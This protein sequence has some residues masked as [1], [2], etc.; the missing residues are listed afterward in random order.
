VTE[1][2]LKELVDRFPTL[3]HMAEGG[4]WPSIREHGLL[5]TS[6][7]LDLLNVQGGDRAAIESARRSECAVI[8]RPPLGNVV[9]RDQKP[10][11]DAGLR[12][13]LP[14][15]TT[16]RD[17]YELLN[18]RV[19]FWLTRDRLLRLLSAGAYRAG[20]H[21]VLELETAALVRD[22]R[23]L[24]WLCPM[25]SG[26]TKPFA[27]PRGPN[28]FARI[29]D[30]PYAQWCAKRPRGEPVVELCVDHAVPDIEPYVRRVVRMQ[31]GREI[32]DVYRREPG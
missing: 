19:F 32:G 29:P 30:Y 16:P 11:T 4:S 17:W 26:C 15:G 5:S 14:P 24:I 9:I 20:E 7:L 13:A 31:A 22:V 8:K 23:P 2:E 25:N 21:D 1:D 12:R 27:H 28:T 6:A 18:S 3:Y 10:M